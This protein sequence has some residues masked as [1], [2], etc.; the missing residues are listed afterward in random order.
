MTTQ[1]SSSQIYTIEIQSVLSSQPA[2][3]KLFLGK[4]ICETLP[5]GTGPL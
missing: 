1:D 5:R 2:L 3:T 4:E